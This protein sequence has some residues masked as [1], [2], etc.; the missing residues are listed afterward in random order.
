MGFVYVLLLGVGVIYALVTGALGWFSDL[1]VGDDIQVDVSGHFDAGHAHPISGTTIATFITGFGAGGVVAHY[2]LRWTGLASLATAAVSGIVLAVAAYLVLELIF[3]QTQ[4]GAE[5]ATGEVV[6]R[7]AEV[8]TPIPAGGTGEV[9]YL[10]RGQR[11]L[12]AARTSDGTA[13]PRGQPVVIERVVGQTLYVRP[14]A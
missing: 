10:A 9:A 11:E 1:G 6:G 7:D 4:A 12:A 5:Y 14:R 8:V 13:V 2:L 3:S